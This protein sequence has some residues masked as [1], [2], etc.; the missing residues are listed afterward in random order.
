[1]L[2]EG[3]QSSWT[4]ATQAETHAFWSWRDGVSLRVQ[5]HRGGKSSDDIAVPVE[6]LAEAVEETLA[7][8]R[9]HRLEACSWGH[10][11]DGNLHS[12]FLVDPRDAD[13]VTRAQAASEE[14]F[15]LA[16]RL[17]GTISGEH[18]V[19][20]VKGGRLALQWPEPALGLHEAVKRAFDPKNL[21]NPGKK[22]AR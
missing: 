19:G 3:A 16:A 4:P 11:G 6:R 17:G 8:G 2:A 5:A 9:R 21:F 12:T 13:E 20:L 18:G 1:V 22:R 15:E 10:A 7:I 14:L